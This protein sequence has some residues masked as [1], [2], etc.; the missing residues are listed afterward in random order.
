MVADAR[1]RGVD[2]LVV[3]TRAAADYFSR[4]GFTPIDPATI[5]P[6]LLASG[7]FASI[8]INETPL[9]TAEL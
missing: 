9:L 6:E 1:L 5:P 3:G 7:E 2:T 8:S 4:L